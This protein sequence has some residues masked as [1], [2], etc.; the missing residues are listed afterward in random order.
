MIK[1]TW[2]N[3]FENKLNSNEKPI[4]A[5]FNRYYYT[6]YNK[7]LERALAQ[8]MLFSSDM[9]DIFK[10]DD[11]I[12]MYARL[13]EDIGLSF[14]NWYAR[15]FDKYIT[16]GVNPNEF[17]MSWTVYFRQIGER[18]GA[19]RVTLVQGTAKRNLSKIV[20]SLSADEVY[21][22][23]GQDVKARMLRRKFKQ[24][25]VYQS[26]RLV[27]TESTNA[28][29]YGTMKSAETIFPNTQMKKEWISARDERTRASHLSANGQIVDFNSDFIVQGESLDHPG[30]SSGSASNVVNCRCSVAPFPVENAQAITDLIGISGIL[31]NIGLNEAITQITE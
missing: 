16:K 19:E 2:Q 5:R 17:E 3:D 12:L 27:R 11:L 23:S 9:T 21:Q 10:E 26:Q 15:N 20:R 8:G 7:I 31:T 1:E 4:I 22:T 13:Y 29:N 24:Y 30:D 6:E 14:A 28:A 25:S 18:V